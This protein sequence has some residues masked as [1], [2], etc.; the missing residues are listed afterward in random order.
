VIKSIFAITAALRSRETL[1]SNLSSEVF[2]Q[3]VEPDALLLQG[4]HQI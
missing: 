2:S 3:R 4:F 1:P